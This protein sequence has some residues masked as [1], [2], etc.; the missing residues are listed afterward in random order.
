MHRTVNAI[1]TYQLRN[2]SR[3]VTTKRV[4]LVVSSNFRY[5]RSLFSIFVLKPSNFGMISAKRG[6]KSVRFL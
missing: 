1:V 6:I 4:I 3:S 5:F 2:S